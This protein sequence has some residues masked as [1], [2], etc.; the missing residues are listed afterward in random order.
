MGFRFFRFRYFGFRLVSYVRSTSMAILLDSRRAQSRKAEA[1]DCALP[2]E[3]LFHRQRVTTA[4]ILQVQQAASDSHHHFGLAPDDPSF[5]V[6][7]RQ[8]GQSERTAIGSDHVAYAR[9]PL[10]L[11]HF[12][13]H[14]TTLLPVGVKVARRALKKPKTP[15]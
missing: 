2:G 8:I 10:L 15:G 12:S 6:G 7:R 14:S 3:E 5:R 13:H 4:R 11:A 9:P 1:L